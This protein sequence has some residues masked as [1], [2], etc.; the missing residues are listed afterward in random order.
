MRRVDG[1][2]QGALGHRLGL[3]L[4]NPNATATPGRC[5]R[6]I[7]SMV[8][9]LFLTETAREFGSVFLPACSSFEKDGTFMN[10]ERRI[11]RVRAALRPAGA[12]EARLA[13]PLRR[14]AGDGR[15]AGSRSRARRK[16]GTRCGPCAK[17]GAG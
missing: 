11:Q 8:Q 14:R 2:L 13:D 3:L 17:A 16:S 12:V 4:T 6:S 9:D 15:H 10:A 7:S 1:R 5:D